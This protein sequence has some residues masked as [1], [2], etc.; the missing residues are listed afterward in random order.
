MKTSKKLRF[1]TKIKLR[2]AFLYILLVFMIA[3]AFVISFL[4]LSN[5]STMTS[6]MLTVSRVIYFG[7]MIY[8]VYKISKYQKLLKSI[9]ELK[10]EKEK[11]NDER[12]KY[13]HLISGGTVWDI[14][15]FIQLF[16]TM[17][18]AIYDVIPFI[19]T[20]CTLVPMIL[21]KLVIYFYLRFRS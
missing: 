9:P 20:M 5:E 12:R 8:A 21:I 13:I 11:E 14:L 7:G 2:I 15:F 1:S 16:L 6:M 19:F 17:T 3:Y 18:A 4:G 10:E